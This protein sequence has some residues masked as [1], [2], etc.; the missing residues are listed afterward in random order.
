[1]TAR[2]RRGGSRYQR[3]PRRL[4]RACFYLRRSVA[5]HEVIQIYNVARM[6][7]IARDRQVNVNGTRWRGHVRRYLLPATRKASDR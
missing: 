6:A 5:Y 7:R 2:A 1:M 4:L 3:V